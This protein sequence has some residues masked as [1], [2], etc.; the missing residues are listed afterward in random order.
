VYD[1]HPKSAQ[2]EHSSLVMPPTTMLPTGVPSPYYGAPDLP[3]WRQEL[4]DASE[5]FRA[6]HHQ[7][8]LGKDKLRKLENAPGWPILVRPFSTTPMVTIHARFIHHH[9]E[10]SFI[11]TCAKAVAR[12]C[13]ATII[14]SDSSPGSCTS[15]NAADTCLMHQCR[16]ARAPVNGVSDVIASST[17]HRRPS[18]T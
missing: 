4:E 6:L 8:Y 9:S 11:C 10:A 5:Q 7:V 17:Q 1:L 2:V 18:C 3:Y 15:P 14:A 16:S 12:S 13:C